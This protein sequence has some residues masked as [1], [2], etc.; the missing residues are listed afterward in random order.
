MSQD[1]FLR[2]PFET[3]V[4]NDAFVLAEA[5]GDF[6]GA[7]LQILRELEACAHPHERN[8]ARAAYP[9]NNPGARPALAWQAPPAP[10]PEPFVS[11][12]HDD[13]RRQFDVY[14]L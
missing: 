6:E 11:G 8:Q 13:G 4:A 3:I 1:P 5:R 10:T 2:H 9:A 12:I 7:R 14:K